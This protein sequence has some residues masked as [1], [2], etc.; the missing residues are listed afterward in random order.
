MKIGRLTIAQSTI[1]L[2]AAAALVSACDSGTPSGS[3]PLSPNARASH[4]RHSILLSTIVQFHNAG[5]STISATGSAPCWTVSPSPLPSVASGES[6]GPVTLN[7][8]TSCLN[9]TNEIRI[10]YAPSP[11]AA[12]CT[13]ITY[14]EFGWGYSANPGP[15]GCTW[16]TTVNPVLYTYALTGSEY[17][18]RH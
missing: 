18:R 14:Y 17:K 1:S 10:T 11:Q 8:D 9:G 4:V 12:G 6:S 15:P 13:F 5:S 2:V 3:G 7:Y 16:N